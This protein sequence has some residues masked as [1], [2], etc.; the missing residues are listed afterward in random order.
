VNF[1]TVKSSTALPAAIIA[2]VAALTLALTGSRSGRAYIAVESWFL[3]LLKGNAT[4]N[5]EL[6]RS[7][8]PPTPEKILA[9]RRLAKNSRGNL[10]CSS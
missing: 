2:L 9:I 1:I 5:P 8:H 4:H 10:T 6:S 7:A 3:C